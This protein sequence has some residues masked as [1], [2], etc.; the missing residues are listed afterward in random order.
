MQHGDHR[1]TLA[2]Q[3]AQQRHQVVG[4]M[5]VDRGKGLVQQ[6]HRR[7]LHQHPRKQRALHLPA[8]QGVHAAPGGIRQAYRFQRMHAAFKFV[9]A[10]T[11][12]R[13]HPSPGAHDHQIQ[14]RDRKRSVQFG[15]LRQP[16]Q[17]GTPP[18]ADAHAARHGAQHA[19]DAF[20]QG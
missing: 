5:G 17:F 20:D 14:H 19:H 7:V 1:A 10:K 18:A 6:Q 16:G 12:P 3:P 11:A 8:R 9:V 15:R 4:G 2:V 13:A